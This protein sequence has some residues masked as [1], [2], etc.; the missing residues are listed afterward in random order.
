MMGALTAESAE[1]A[2]RQ[3]DA[4][5]RRGWVSGVAANNSIL[6]P[7][8]RFFKNDY[9]PADGVSVWRSGG[10]RTR[11]AERRDRRVRRSRARR[12]AARHFAGEEQP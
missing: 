10:K 8:T 1:T 9:S 2:T 6:T 5:R 4:I 7:T 3:G 11:R 12:P